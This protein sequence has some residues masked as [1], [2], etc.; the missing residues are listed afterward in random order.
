MDDPSKHLRR[1]SNQRNRGDL[2]GA[3]TQF[4]RALELDPR[5]AA[6]HSGL[7]QTYQ[8]KG[9]WADALKAYEACLE[10]EPGSVAAM[11]GRGD[12][13]THLG[14][15]EPAAQCYRRSIEANPECF[16]SH[17]KLGRVLGWMGRLDE[18]IAC[19]EKAQALAPPD[20]GM[21]EA[22]AD[23][24]ERGRFAHESETTPAGPAEKREGGAESG[25]LVPEEL[26]WQGKRFLDPSGR[27][28]VHNNQVY[29]AIYPEARSR[30]EKMFD[31][32]V[33]EHLVERGL[34]VRTRRTKLEVPGYA[35]VL[36]HKRIAFQTIRGNWHRYFLKDAAR[37]VLDLNLELLRYGLRTVAYHY[38][39]V[40]QQG[41]CRPVWIDFGSIARIGPNANQEPRPVPAQ[42]RSCYLYPLALLAKSADLT[43]P[44]RRLG[45]LEWPE[46]A[47]LVGQSSASKGI[48][49]RTSEFK[50]RGAA[51]M[52]AR[53][54]V[55]D[56]ELPPIN[57]PW[58]GYYDR[59]LD[60]LAHLEE[61]RF[62]AVRRAIEERRP[63]RVIDL[64]CNA[65]RFSV[66]AARTGADVYA[67]DTDYGALETLYQEVKSLEDPLSITSSLFDVMGTRLKFRPLGD[68]VLALALTHHLAV[69]ERYPFPLIAKKLSS[70]TTDALIAEFMPYGR[71]AA[72]PDPN[73]E[74]LPA[75]YRLENFLD[76]LAACFRHVQVID[77]PRAG[78]AERVLILCRYPRQQASA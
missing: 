20:A 18:T 14:R 67:A 76:A 77:Y 6:A 35:M 22:L 73:P 68:L 29:R 63:K 36:K 16:E 43:A 39:N 51:L 59:P 7:A 2:A 61:R 50:G 30:V 55:D 5:S 34:L 31:D 46:F 28:F 38:G 47:A 41:R 40:K 58:E 65:G 24:R 9:R 26:D 64:G 72:G 70:Y 37:C 25:N 27:V 23:M 4:T 53:E 52:A 78:R 3:V 54:W 45:Q 56:L 8:L 57:S 74:P 1:G 33:V 75:T 17:R 62:T 69:G 71:R 42:L 12:V 44:C 48:F 13:L 15:L 11:R 21:S 32:G 49:A 60:K 10:I 66:V 19:L